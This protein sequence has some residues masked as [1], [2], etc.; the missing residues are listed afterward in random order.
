MARTVGILYTAAY[1]AWAAY[2]NVAKPRHS[3]TPRRPAAQR[4][5]AN[6]RKAVSQAIYRA[7][8]DRIPPSILASR[9]PRRSKP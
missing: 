2:D 9:F 7:L 1:D 6:R 4:T 8:V 3:T 5:L